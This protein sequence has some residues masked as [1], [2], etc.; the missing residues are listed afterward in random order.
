M[1]PETSHEH[2]GD[3]LRLTESSGLC[4][5]PG[6]LSCEEAH[7]MI[8]MIVDHLSDSNTEQ[9]FNEHVGDCP[10]C[11]SEFIVYERIVASLT[12]AR[13]RIPDEAASRIHEFCNGLSDGDS[14]TIIDD[15]GDA[16]NAADEGAT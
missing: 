1:N 3:Q 14:S 6:Q 2:L 12:R 11:E 5:G 16:S 9:L 4:G 7:E 10:P 13:P 8:Q 15:H